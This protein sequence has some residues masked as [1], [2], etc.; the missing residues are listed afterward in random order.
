MRKLLL[1]TITFIGLANPSMAQVPNYV[2]TS[3]LMGW[4]PFT[5]NANDLSVNT[6]NGIVNGATLTSD[7]FGNLNSAY[8]FNGIN[9]QIN[10][11]STS[12]IADFPAGQTISFWMKINAYPTDGKEHSM[13]DKRSNDAKY[14]Q[15]FISNYTGVN[16]INY[17]YG[18]SGSLS[19][20]GS[21]MPFAS[22]PL[23]QWFN[24][25]YSTDL[26]I[27][28]TYING[29][30]FQTYNQYSPIGINTNPL[31]FG[32]TNQVNST[33]APYNGLLDDIGIWNRVLTPCE[34]TQLYNAS[35]FNTPTITAV[36]ST[37]FCLGNSS[38]LTTST[39]GTYTWSTGANT[40][41]I[42][43]SNA[44]SYSVSV[45]NG[46]CIGNASP[47][48]ISVNPTPTISVSN[49]TICIGDSYSITPSGASTYT[50]S[51]GSA[52]VSP[53]VNSSY[54]IIG[55]SSL[56]CVSSNT[57]VCSL[58]VNTCTG[59][60]ELLSNSTPIYPNP[61]N[62]LFTIEL[63]ETTQVIITSILGNV[64][65]KSTLD[66]GKQTLDIKNY[67]NGI[68]FVQLAQDGKLQTIKLIKE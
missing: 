61:S 59:I 19:S 6:N 38:T 15:A 55:T 13:I 52:V 35:V 58:I 31:I 17:R 16:T 57:A 9:N 10:V 4:W 56:G 22:V 26:T 29:V 30:L 43:V 62:G 68:Y 54:S 48:V 11:A 49:A 20:Q 7:R 24:L 25:C 63:N 33:N 1:I 40:Q 46:S 18:Q 12:S 23:N 66:A 8:N 41:S 39:I 14:Y 44:G 67:A 27:T 47:V 5:G 64:L 45:T 60:N 53:T 2:P 36:S 42:T 50:Y 34:I 28:K 3:G 21:N 65:F 32:N 51:S 37:T